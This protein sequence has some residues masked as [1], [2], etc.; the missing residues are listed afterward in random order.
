[1]RALCVAAVLAAV[2]FTNGASAEQPTEAEIRHVMDFIH[3]QTGLPIPPTLPRIAQ[4]SIDALTAMY[5][6]AVEHGLRVVEFNDVDRLYLLDVWDRR[7][8]DDMGALV[9]GLTHV[10]QAG[11]LERYRCHGEAE[12]EAYRV[13]GAWL[14]RRGLSLGDVG[15]S[16]RLVA[17]ET[18]CGP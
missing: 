5:P 1:M 10:M 13:Q 3:A 9:H 15:V 18:R 16:A 12:A 4:R 14:A 17:V 6:T 11:A 2:M 8:P 7:R